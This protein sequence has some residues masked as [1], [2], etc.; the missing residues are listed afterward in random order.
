MG[1]KARHMPSEVEP[2][3]NTA[4]SRPTSRAAKRADIPQTSPKQSN[5]AF[6]PKTRSSPPTFTPKTRSSPPTFPPKAKGSPPTFSSKPRSS[7]P[8]FPFENLEFTSY[9]PSEYQ[10]CICHT[11]S[12]Q[13][14][15]PSQDQQYGDGH[16]TNQV[17]T[18]NDHLVVAVK[19]GIS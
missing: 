2:E 1:G 3:W 15:L 9:I 11:K 5:R 16:K 6:P 19:R 10:Q 7:P 17:I 4:L 18:Y 8:T 12:C 14:T 13:F